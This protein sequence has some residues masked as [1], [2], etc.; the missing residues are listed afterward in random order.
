MSGHGRGG[1]SEQRDKLA[2]A[3]FTAFEGRD[4]PQPIFIGQG[5][6]HRHQFAHNHPSD[7][8]VTEA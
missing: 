2:Q 3:Q 1:Q 6:H 8:L 4:H 5:L 7:L